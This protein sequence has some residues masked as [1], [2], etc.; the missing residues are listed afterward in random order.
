[1]SKKVAMTARIPWDP[2]ITVLIQSVS[3]HIE[4]AYGLL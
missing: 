1:M 4:R 2:N 3:K